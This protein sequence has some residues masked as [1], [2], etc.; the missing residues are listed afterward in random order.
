MVKVGEL[1][2]IAQEE[3]R[4]VVAYK[5]PIALFGIELDGKSAYIALC[6]GCSALPCHR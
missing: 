2:R 1:Q 6:I 5:V 3:Y 4:G